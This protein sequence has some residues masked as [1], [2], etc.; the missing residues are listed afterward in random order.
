MDKRELMHQQNVCASV[1]KSVIGQTWQV[2]DQQ[3]DRASQ[4]AAFRVL[5]RKAESA[6]RAIDDLLDWIAEEIGIEDEDDES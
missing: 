5:E 3:S 1:C 6:H 2:F 4:E